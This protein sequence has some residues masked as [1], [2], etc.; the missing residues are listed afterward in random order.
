M[1]SASVQPIITWDQYKQFKKLA[2][3]PKLLYML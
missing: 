3:K 2:T 1:T